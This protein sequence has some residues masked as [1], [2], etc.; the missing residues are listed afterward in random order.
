MISHMFK[1]YIAVVILCTLSIMTIESA[2]F[3]V[4]IQFDETGQMFV[5]VD[6]VNI[7]LDSNDILKTKNR[8]CTRTISLAPPSEVEIAN[9]SGYRGGSRQCG[10]LQSL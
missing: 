5:N 2:T 1:L 9:R 10:P 6:G 3:R 8:Y 4:P 7:S